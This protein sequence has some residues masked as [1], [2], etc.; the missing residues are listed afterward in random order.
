MDGFWQ[1]LLLPP[2]ISGVTINTVWIGPVARAVLY[3]AMA[4][5]FAAGLLAHLSRRYPAAGAVRRALLAALFAAGILYALRAD[6]GWSVWVTRDLAALGGLTTEEKLL[7]VNGGVYDF[8][9]RARA[10][11]SGDYMIYSPDSYLAQR[12]EYFL[13]PLRR[14]SDAPVI[15]VLADP[16]AVYDPARRVFTRSDVRMDN[17]SLLMRYGPDAYIVGRQ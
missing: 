3:G 7:K 5:A 16:T 11:V 4:A 6:I 15:I 9:R 14:R 10:V 13:L 17:V 1:Q 8:S 2:P 12:T